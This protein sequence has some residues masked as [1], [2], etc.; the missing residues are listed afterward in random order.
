MKRPELFRFVI[1]V[2]EPV[3]FHFNGFELFV[4][5]NTFD[6]WM[7]LPDEVPEQRLLDFHE[8]HTWFTGV[9]AVNQLDI[10]PVNS[11][12]PVFENAANQ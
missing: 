4:G 1:D 12:N 2:S 3:N 10:T 6:I 9:G 7:T 11:P 8:F 5:T